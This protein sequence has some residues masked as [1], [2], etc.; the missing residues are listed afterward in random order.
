DGVRTR[1]NWNHNPVSLLPASPHKTALL[2]YFW[3]RICTFFAQLYARKSVV[4]S[5]LFPC[6]RA[7]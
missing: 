7:A 6:E 2:S 1:D 4:V 5:V 3:G